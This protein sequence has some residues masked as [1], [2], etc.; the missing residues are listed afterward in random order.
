MASVRLHDGS[1]IDFEAHGDGPVLLLPVDPAPLEG[2]KAEAMR[3]WGADPA[4]GQSLINGLRDRF[5]VVA[6][7]YEGHVMA[8]PK[9]ETLTPAN[10]ARDLLAVADAAG[11][12]RFAYYGYSWLGL[13]G[14]QL[15]LHTDRLSALVMGGYPPVGGPYAAMLAVTTAAHAASLKAV[16]HPPT[17]A[18]TVPGDW[19]TVS[20]VTTVDQT[21]QFVTL[22]ESLRDFDDRAAQPSLTCPRLCVVGSADTMEYGEQWGG[23]TVDIAGPVQR[24]RAALE[25]LGWDVAVLDGLDHMRA[26]QA[27]AVLPVLRPWL[28]SRL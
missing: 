9:P 15:A 26:M 17:P 24:E 23:V 11:A 20:V 18:E 3:A 25:A 19:S 5:R 2:P 8:H 7:D 21:R 27:A 4:L 1:T 22:Y 16:Q 13:L 12:D 14:Q 6:F 28:E 10:A